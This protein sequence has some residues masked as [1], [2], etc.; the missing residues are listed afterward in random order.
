MNKNHVNLA[1][2]KLKFEKQLRVGLNTKN[3]KL[4]D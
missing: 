2:I 1:F 3:R 4:D